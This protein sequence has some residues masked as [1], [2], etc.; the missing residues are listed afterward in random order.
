MPETTTP[1]EPRQS[2]A[3]RSAQLAAVP[4]DQAPKDEP[5][6][7]ETPKP[8]PQPRPQPEVTVEAV[9]VTYYRPTV[10][11]P[12]G[13]TIVCEHKYLHE[14]EKAAASCGRRIAALGAFVK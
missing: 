5:K 13:T 3:A 7:S 9:P 4:A 6:P 8:K 1:A 11:L 10:K 2:R 14:N 12:D